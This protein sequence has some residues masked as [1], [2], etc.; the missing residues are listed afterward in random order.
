MMGEYLSGFK[1]PKPLLMK[2]LKKKKGGEK[3]VGEPVVEDEPED[4]RLAPA[5]VAAVQSGSVFRSPW[6][7]VGVALILGGGGYWVWRRR[8]RAMGIKRGK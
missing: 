6:L 7:W 2:M 4:A 8:R 1:P 3:K 5:R